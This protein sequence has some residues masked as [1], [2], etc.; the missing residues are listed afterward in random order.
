MRARK[1]SKDTKPLE[2][3]IVRKSIEKAVS[4]RLKDEEARR[5]LEDEIRELKKRHASLMNQLPVGISQ[6]T[7]DGRF[8]FLNDIGAKTLGFGATDDAMEKG[9]IPLYKDPQVRERL[10]R[11]LLEKGG[12]ENYPVNVTTRT[13]GTVNLLLSS[14]IEGEVITSIIVDVTEL[15]T[16]EEKLIKSQEQLRMLASRLRSIREEERK[17]IAREVHDELGQ[18][19]TAL[20]I[21]LNWL[22]GQLAEDYRPLLEKVGSMLK[23][24]DSS[25]RTVKR[26]STE[27][28]P[29]VLDDLGLTAAIEWQ[30]NNF[31]ELTGIPCNVTLDPEAIA[32]EPDLST[33][34]FRIYQET[35]TNIM[36]HAHATRVEVGLKSESDRIVLEVSDN[37]RGIREKEITSHDSIGLLGMRERVYPW[38]GEVVIEGEEGKGTTVRVS[39]PLERKDPQD[40]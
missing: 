23:R 33:E 40:D 24:I 4:K 20:S 34:I 15:R 31:H 5:H 10:I 25:I 27:L 17:R 29:K 22:G 11:I 26:I 9:T 19:L 21:D 28:R 8:L 3:K 13:G 37:G 36:R 14:R 2:K 38:G 7:V 32:I 16:A 35:L 1:G 6:S 30:S 12:F 18:S 39:I